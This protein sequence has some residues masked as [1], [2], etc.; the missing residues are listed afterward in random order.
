MT[1]TSRKIVT[2]LRLN[3][4]TVRGIIHGKEKKT[5]PKGTPALRDQEK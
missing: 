1:V 3:E 4:V 2:A 5:Q